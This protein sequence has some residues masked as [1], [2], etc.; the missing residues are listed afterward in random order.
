[1]E[2]KKKLQLIILVI[3]SLLIS[4][5]KSQEDPGEGIFEE[6]SAHKI[7]EMNE[8]DI[9][10]NT[11]DITYFV[12]YYKRT[13]KTSRMIAP[14]IGILSRKLE[15]IAEFLLID[16]DEEKL[17]SSELC[18]TE[19]QDLFP[20][21][22]LLVPPEYRLNPYTKKINT[23]AEYPLTE[24]KVSE[25]ILFNFITKYI[26]SHSTKLSSDNIDNFIK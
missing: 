13:S 5:Y 21:M 6:I 23:Y 7:K 15:N 26:H 4:L 10:K 11:T 22:K 2:N 19:N 17:K 20:R 18:Q 8:I 16:C 3:L 25:P 12:Y 24:D 9:L 14:I 1:M